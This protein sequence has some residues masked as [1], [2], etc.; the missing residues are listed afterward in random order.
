MVY[1]KLKLSMMQSWED[2][3]LEEWLNSPEKVV[4]IWPN[5]INQNITNTVFCVLKLAA[6][7]ILQIEYGLVF[8]FFAP[9]LLL[10]LHDDIIILKMVAVF[11]WI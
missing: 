2:H 10:F 5:L 6:N 7:L 11:N 1:N 3:Y 9:S 8:I 4:G